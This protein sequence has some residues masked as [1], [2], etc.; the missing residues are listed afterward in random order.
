MLDDI[1]MARR[2]AASIN[3]TNNAKNRARAGT[4][5]DFYELW[6]ESQIRRGEYSKVEYA[7]NHRNECIVEI[8]KLYERNPKPT[9]QKDDYRA[10]YEILERHSQDIVFNDFVNNIVFPRTSRFE[11]WKAKSRDA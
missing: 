7:D 9:K 5:E 11:K 6:R 10:V 2:V 4:P 1:T 3:G 8:R